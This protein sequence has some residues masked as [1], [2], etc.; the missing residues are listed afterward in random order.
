MRPRI[1]VI[2]PTRERADTLVHALRTVVQQ[3]YDDV[4]IIVSDNFSQDQTRQVV[5]SFGDSRI[6]YLNTGRRISMSHN[7]EFALSHVTHG[8]VT[9]LGDDDGLLPGGLERIGALIGQTDCKAITTRWCHYYWPGTGGNE[10]RL[11]VPLGRKVERRNGQAWLGKLLRGSASYMELPWLYT[12]GFVEISLVNSARVNN[13]SFFLSITPDI[14]SAIAISSVAGDY[15]M[16]DEPVSVAG[17]SHH[18]NGAS[19]FGCE[20]PAASNQ[21]LSENTI[22]FHAM[23]GDIPVKSLS[24]LTYECY[25]QAAHLRRKTP[26]DDIESQLALAIRVAPSTDIEQTRADCM[27]IA[28]IN[29]ISEQTINRQLRLAKRLPLKPERYL[30]TTINTHIYAASNVADAAI[31][32]HTLRTLHH[33]VFTFRYLLSTIARETRHRIERARNFVLETV[34]DWLS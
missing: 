24:L 25:L 19:F 13:G 14:Y 11:S 31:L 16:V 23:L 5:E 26:Q 15:L 27:R 9:F 21:Y 6:R 7:W 32:A 17:V 33:T 4:Q 22:P 2:I 1:N 18:S 10:N 20:N 30:L 12:G 28:S 34:L 29:S 8:W 3:D